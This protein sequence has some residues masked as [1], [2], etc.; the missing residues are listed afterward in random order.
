[1]EITLT[2]IFTFRVS[3]ELSGMDIHGYFEYN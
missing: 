3:H 1:M 2:D